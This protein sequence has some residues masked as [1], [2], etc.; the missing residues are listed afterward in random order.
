MPFRACFHFSEMGYTQTLQRWHLLKLLWA[1]NTFCIVRV[2]FS[3]FGSRGGGGLSAVNTP[4]R[5]IDRLAR[6]IL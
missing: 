3:D 2:L 4:E 1:G 6:A 5:P